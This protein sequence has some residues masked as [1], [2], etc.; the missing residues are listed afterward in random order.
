MA[1]QIYSPT[2]AKIKA[3]GIGG[4]GCNAITRMVHEGIKGVDFIAMNTDAQALA[5]VEAPTRIQ[6]GEKISRG[7]GA[8]GDRQVGAWAARESIDAIEN[9]IGSADMV[10]IV[11]G[12][13]GGTGTGGIPVVAEVA[14]QSG[15][16]T[17]AVVTKP[18]TFEGKNR[19]QVAEEGLMNLAHKVDTLIIIPSDRILQLY[20]AKVM[21]VDNAFRL[22]D[23]ALCLVV[24]AISEV[25]TVPGLI[26]LDFA[27]ITSVMRDAGPAWMSVAR[28]SGQNRATE[29]AKAAMTSPSFDVSISKA[30][31][32]LFNITGGP[33]LTLFECNEAAQVVSEAVDPDANIIFGVVFDPK[34]GS[35]VR[36]T[37]IATGFARHVGRRISS[38]EELLSLIR[39]S[40]DVLEVPSFLRRRR[41]GPGLR[42]AID[43]AILAK[44]YSIFKSKLD[45]EERS[46]RLKTL[47]DQ[48]AETSPDDPAVELLNSLWRLSQNVSSVPD[49]ASVMIR[50]L[51]TQSYEHETNPLYIF[52]SFISSAC[53]I[54]S[55]SDFGRIPLEVVEAINQLQFEFSNIVKIPTQ[56]VR[57]FQMVESLSDQSFIKLHRDW[58]RKCEEV[59]SELATSLKSKVQTPE[60]VC[61]MYVINQWL[62]LVAEGIRIS[63]SNLK[64][65]LETSKPLYVNRMNEIQIAISGGVSGQPLR[66]HAPFTPN[67][68]VQLDDTSF[69]FQGSVTNICLHIRPHVA[70]PLNILIEIEGVTHQIEGLALL[71]NPFV[72]GRPVLSEDMFVGRQEIVNRIIRGIVAP[73]PTDF[74]IVGR[75][76][77]GKT[78]LLHAIKRQ[79]PKSFLPVLISTERCGKDPREVCQALAN[80]IA[81]SITQTQAAR[82]KEKQLPAILQDD[83][84]GSFISWLETT[85]SRLSSSSFD[86][87]VLLIDEALDITEWDDR[88]QRLLR[89]TFSS[90]TWIRSVL[91]GPPDIIERMTEHVSS[92]LYNIFTTLKLG[93]IDIDDTCKLIIA[94][95]KNCGIADAEDMLNTIYDYSGGIPYYIQAIGHELI[96]NY[97]SRNLTGEE[98][99]SS[100]LAQIRGRLKTSYPVTLKKLSAEQKVS[101]VLVASGVNPPE[102]S[103]IRL[104]QADLIEREGSKWIV[105]AR[106]EREWVKEYADQLLDS[107]GQELWDYH[108]KELDLL[109]L[110]EDL[111]KLKKEFATSDEVSEALA[112][113]ISAAEKE[114]G[115]KT[116]KYLGKVGQWVLDTAIKIG[117]EVAATAIKRIYGL[118]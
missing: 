91:A 70:G 8:G 76:R 115:A 10:F 13:G 68:D 47:R 12:M 84:T 41:P 78:S 38:A 103:A 58:L 107:A 16:L 83:P 1:R 112:S 62:E 96:E 67:Y 28:A 17:I 117:A 90:M 45:C 108:K 48:I 113:A 89:Y 66:I 92:P 44:G 82:P 33:S 79:L 27:D 22:A 110:A 50:L 9:V 19:A 43:D 32:V 52:Y 73:Q 51:Q 5:L 18:F 74:L 55:V 53:D 2:P 34:M 86:A 36:I 42:L 7:L 40:R 31:G 111:R 114:N 69:T 80:E 72:V 94:P 81:K 30:T 35:E 61:L 98:L 56:V 60:V 23:N 29:A 75:R 15:A 21:S 49:H 57:L 37:V 100:S 64:C 6:L 118:Q 39:G 106:I 116:L 105:R 59:L 102:V 11:A 104:E 26:N 71:E 95:L 85:R 3:I 97:F 93:P 65:Y 109:Q 101:I 63:L 88:V 99:L 24:Q 20:D 87:M 14:K 46:S 54:G 77:I 25:V 4:G